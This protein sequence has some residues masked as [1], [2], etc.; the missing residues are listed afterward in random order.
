MSRELD[1]AEDHLALHTAATTPGNPQTAAISKVIAVVRG[2]EG[3]LGVAEGWIADVSQRVRTMRA[4]PADRRGTSITTVLGENYGASWRA[5]GVHARDCARCAAWT[6]QVGASHGGAR[7]H[8][9]MCEEGRKIYYVT[10]GEPVAEPREPTV[11]E[12]AIPAGAALRPEP[13]ESGEIA[14]AVGAAVRRA[15]VAR[16]GEW[17]LAYARGMTHDREFPLSRAPGTPAELEKLLHE[18]PAADAAVAAMLNDFSADVP[19][20]LEAAEAAVRRF[21]GGNPLDHPAAVLAVEAA[22]RQAIGAAE[23][24]VEEAEREIE[25]QRGRVAQR[26]ADD[27]RTAARAAGKAGDKE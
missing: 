23:A 15:V 6:R 3:R 7:G 10:P 24:R 5:L 1:E 18:Q 12:R 2:L 4:S 14:A 26:D 17:Q 19:P 16:D 11:E 25:Y 13:E 9:D 21:T 20:P 22:I 27:A 8:D